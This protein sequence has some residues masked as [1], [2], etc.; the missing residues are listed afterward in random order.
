LKRHY[1]NNHDYLYK[2]NFYFI[3]LYDFQN[4]LQLIEGK[5]VGLLKSD[6]QETFEILST[7]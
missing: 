4:V 1:N 5:S 3:S 6:F 7:Q 2:P